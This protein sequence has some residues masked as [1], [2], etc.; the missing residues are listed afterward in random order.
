MTTAKKTPTKRTV[1]KVKPATDIPAARRHDIAMAMHS[2]YEA[3]KRIKRDPDGAREWLDTAQ[4][5][6]D[7]VLSGAPS[8]FE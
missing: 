5:L 6:L 2:I 8:I 7:S 4:D 1:R 3:R